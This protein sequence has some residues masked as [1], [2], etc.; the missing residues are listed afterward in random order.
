MRL[1]SFT[2]ESHRTAKEGVIAPD[3]IEGD[4]R[5]I[6]ENG[7]T[8]VQ[9]FVLRGRVLRRDATK[10]NASVGNSIMCPHFA[11]RKRVLSRRSSQGGVQMKAEASPKKD[12]TSRARDR[13]AEE[14]TMDT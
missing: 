1:S 3:H 14:E 13:N 6:E 9:H 4:R 2:G 10:I 8:S 5:A 7:S 11:V 12:R